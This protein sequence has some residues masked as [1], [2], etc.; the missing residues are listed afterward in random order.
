MSRQDCLEI[1]AIHLDF[2]AIRATIIV[3]I[4][5]ELFWRGWLMRWIINPNF[6]EI[7]FGADAR[8]AFWLVAVAFALEHGPYWEVG[9][10]CGIVY[11][12]W[13]VRTKSLGDCW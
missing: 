10:L 13:M 3:P 6:L 5:E 1:A 9:L 11:N 8:D 12:W 2:R 4:V 7:P